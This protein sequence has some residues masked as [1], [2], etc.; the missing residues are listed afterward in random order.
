MQAHWKK[1]LA[2]VV[3]AV[4][5]FVVVKMVGSDSETP[6]GESATSAVTSAG[7]PSTTVT[8]G[9]GAGAGTGATAPT[10]TQAAPNPSAITSGSPIEMTNVLREAELVDQAKTALAQ[11]NPKRALEVIH[12]YEQTPEPRSL[13]GEAALVK[14]DALAK[15]GRR[16][17]ALAFAMSTRDDPAYAPYQKRIELSL[18][19]AGLSE[20]AARPSP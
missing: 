14:I 16:T 13:K 20:G 17:D 10:T 18:V 4:V 1:I 2:L 3:G 12:A 8:T 15:T 9:T 19:D 6:K 7:T 5:L 11:G